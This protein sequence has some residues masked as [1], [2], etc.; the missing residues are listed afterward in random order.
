MTNQ[1]SFGAVVFAKDL[2]RVARFY[3]ELLSLSVGVAEPDLIVLES[4]GFQL[5]VHPLPK[6]V[7]RSITITTPAERRTNVP[8]KL[9]FYVSSLAQARQQAALLG[10]ALD[11]EK[12]EWEARGF[13]ACDGQDPEGNVV[14][15]RQ[16]VV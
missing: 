9:V 15:L 3:E 4:S 2:A 8:T 5:V 14:Q 1:L 7:A 13:R 10:G 16:R 11:P 6:K 12:S